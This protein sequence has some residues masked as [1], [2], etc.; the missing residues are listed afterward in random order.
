MK[1]VVIVHGWKDKVN[2]GWIPWLKEE[3]EKRGYKVEIPEM[4]NP[5]RPKLEDWIKSIAKCVGKPSKNCFF[6]GHSLGCITILRYLETLNEGEEIGGS[7]LIAGFSHD[8]GFIELDTYFDKPI[9]WDEIN[10]HCKKFTVMHSDNDPHV[11]VEQGEIFRQMLDARVIILEGM[12]HFRSSEGVLELPI[13]LNTLLD[14][15]QGE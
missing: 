7:L 6:V 5:N 11:P 1:K 3:C 14:M 2:R 9:E 4:P 8:L 12:Q 10:S 15:M 13:A